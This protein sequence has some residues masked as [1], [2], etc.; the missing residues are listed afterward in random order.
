MS[1][2]HETVILNSNTPYED[3]NHDDNNQTEIK[4]ESIQDQT[5][6]ES[7]TNTNGNTKKNPLQIPSLSYN[8]IS[9]EQATNPSWE[10]QQANIELSEASSSGQT[11][12]ENERF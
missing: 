9:T 6:V 4:S 2:W 1:N 12:A 3:E 11:P 5:S 7:N 8:E 10:L